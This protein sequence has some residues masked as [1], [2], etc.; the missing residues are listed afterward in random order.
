MK[1]F[2][3]VAKCDPYNAK[4]HYLGQ[5]VLKYDGITP[6]H[7]VIEDGF[8]SEE[9]AKK[10]LKNL[11]I[12]SYF[13]TYEDENTVAETKREFEE[14]MGLRY[15]TSWYKGPGIYMENVPVLLEGESAFHDDSM[16]YCVDDYISYGRNND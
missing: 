10:A 9:E 11:A 1:Q 8:A 14:E 6:I 4:K 7:W 15:D 12:D 5:K 13:A 16:T 3:I 2:R